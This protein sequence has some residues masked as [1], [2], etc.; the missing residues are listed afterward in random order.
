MRKR[1]TKILQNIVQPTKGPVTELP[2]EPKPAPLLSYVTLDVL[3]RILNNSILH[4]FIAG[5]LP[6]CLLALATPTDH[7]AVIGTCAW[8]IFLIVWNVAAIIIDGVLDP[9]R[10]VDWETEVVVVTGGSRGL[11]RLLAEVFALRGVAVAALDVADSEPVEGVQ[12]YNCD[13]GD[14]AAVEK[15]VAQITEEV[16]RTIHEPT[17]RIARPAYYIDQ[18]CC[19]S[20]W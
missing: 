1:P 14:A 15:T 2:Q 18:Q 19:Y 12:F 16:C 5:L 4:P 20:A 7:P 17:N 10:E 3:F 11:G 13:V 8:A 9:P 6:I